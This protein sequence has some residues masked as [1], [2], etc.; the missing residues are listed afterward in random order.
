[1]K[2]F[3]VIVHGQNFLIKDDD[4]GVPSLR[5]FYV[6]AFIETET[7]Q[8][9]EKIALDLVKELPRLKK[10]VVNPLNNRPVLSIDES[11]ELNDWPDCTLP[12]SGFVFYEE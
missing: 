12:L 11:A 3:A 10:T 4:S 5:G 9:A 8:E 1:M 6:N 7:A 2:K